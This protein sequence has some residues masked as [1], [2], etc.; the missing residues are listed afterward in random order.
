M[1]YPSPFRDRPHGVVLQLTPLIDCVFLLMVYFLWSSS[2]AV[3]ERTMSAEL[4][5]AGGSA[6]AVSRLP[7]PEAD[8]D[9][10]VVRIVWTGSGPA[11]EVNDAPVP[12]LSKLRETL[13]AVASIKRD[14]PVILHPDAE[15]PLGHVIDVLDLSRI[16]G[17]EKVQFA[18]AE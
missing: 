3:S 14:A 1:R 6:P 5:A 7:L 18:A 13:E 15:V 4:S 8:F 9:D 16:A 12:S 2:F 10:L 11:W 17:Y